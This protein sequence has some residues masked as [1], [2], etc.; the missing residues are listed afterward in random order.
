MTT[1]HFHI[2]WFTDDDA[3]GL[4]QRAERGHG[5]ATVGDAAQLVTPR[6]RRHAPF[7]EPLGRQHV[8]E[9]LRHERVAFGQIRHGLDD[10]LLDQHAQNP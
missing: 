1:I 8:G 10:T 7:V 3:E 5:V 2:G 9:V 4:H 6:A